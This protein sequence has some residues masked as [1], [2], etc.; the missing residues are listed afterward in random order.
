MRFSLKRN[1]EHEAQQI[2]PQPRQWCF[3]RNSVKGAWHSKHVLRLL[4]ATHDV[5]IGARVYRESALDAAE[6]AGVG[7]GMGSLPCSVRPII[8]AA[9][10]NDLEKERSSYRC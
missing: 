10:L 1:D 2:S 6:D 9:I 4:L 5:V 7:M 3:W 8:T